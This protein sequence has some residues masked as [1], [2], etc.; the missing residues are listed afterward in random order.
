MESGYAKLNNK[1]RFVKR[2]DSNGEVYIEPIG[3]EA[4]RKVQ[5]PTDDDDDDVQMD[6][7]DGYN[8]KQSGISIVL[9]SL[10]SQEMHQKVSKTEDDEDNG[11]TGGLGSE[12][13][14]D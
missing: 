3:P 4:Y 7:G 13:E 6:I 9:K 12:M 14:T 11:I 1:K 5:E 2:R 8:N 10:K